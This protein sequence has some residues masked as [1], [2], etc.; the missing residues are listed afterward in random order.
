MQLCRPLWPV[1]Q[2]RRTNRFHYGQFAYTVFHRK[3]CPALIST[4][5]L[6]LIPS[7]GPVS[8]HPAVPYR[9][10]EP[11]LPPPSPQSLQGHHYL[12]S[13]SARRSDRHC[14][15]PP[16]TPPMLPPLALAAPPS[17]PHRDPRA[18][19]PEHLADLIST[20][21]FLAAAWRPVGKAG[22][23]AASAARPEQPDDVARA[24]RPGIR[25]CDSCLAPRMHGVR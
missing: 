22:N 14:C 25:A 15:H 9:H 2:P 3:G 11:A 7:P 12:R 18:A 1:D 19:V 20:V 4:G 5:G 10:L 23:R 17:A 8:H 21:R 16:L 6:S 24:R 13:R